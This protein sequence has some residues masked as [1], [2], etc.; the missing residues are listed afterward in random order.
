MIAVTGANGKLGKQVI[1]KLLSFYPAEKIVGLARNP[2]DAGDLIKLG[3]QIKQADYDKPETVSAALF[4][5]K[6]L[7]LISAVIPSERFRQHKAVID[8]AHQAGVNLIAYTSQL[9]ADT[10]SFSLAKSHRETESYIKKSG[11]AYTILRNGWYIENHT[12]NLNKAVQHGVL[13]GSSGKGRFSSASREE[14]A[15]AAAVVLS[16]DGHI[17]K[18]YELA[19]SDAYTMSELADQVSELIGKK[20]D[21]LNLSYHD[22]KQVLLSVNIP[23]MIADV[24]IEADKLSQEGELFSDS[25]DLSILL[26]RKTLPIQQVIINEIKQKRLG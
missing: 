4:G 14:Y 15:E 25:N 21:Y 24:V 11:M 17:G 9:R 5:I 23:E 22:L 13:L 3:V 1:M 26:G 8:A 6:K 20:I 10:S 7:L 2:Q 16:Q 18:V 19:G 12:D